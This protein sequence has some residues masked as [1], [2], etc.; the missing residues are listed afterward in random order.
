MLTW[1]LAAHSGLLQTFALLD[2]CISGT[3]VV[4]RKCAVSVIIVDIAL[5]SLALKRSFII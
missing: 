4:S 3:R 5:S 1:V 2:P